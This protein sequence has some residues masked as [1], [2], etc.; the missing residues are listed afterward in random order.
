MKKLTLF[1]L[2]IFPLVTLSCFAMDTSTDIT[3]PLHTITA[4]KNDL[5][6]GYQKDEV[7]LKQELDG[8]K[9][10][11]T[12]LQQIESLKKYI[13]DNC[14]FN[15]TKHKDLSIFSLNWISHIIQQNRDQEAFNSLT[16]HISILYE[17]IK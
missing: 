14:I 6:R 11:N 8:N 4:E 12:T 9:T 16:E 5:K 7:T 15:I 1:F 17:E 10:K 3:H 2:N 13:Q